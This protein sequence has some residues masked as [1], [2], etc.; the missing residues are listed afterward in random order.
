MAAGP[1]GAAR[2]E[3]E[4]AVPGAERAEERKVADQNFIGLIS[5]NVEQTL[6]ATAPHDPERHARL[7]ALLGAA[8]DLKA[9][10]RPV[11]GPYW[12]AATP[13]QKDRIVTLLHDHLTDLYADQ[14]ADYDGEVIRVADSKIM[15]ESPSVVRTEIVHPERPL[16]RVDFWVRRTGKTYRVLDVIIEGTSLLVTKR[17]EFQAVI[18]GQGIDGLIARLKG[19]KATPAG[20]RS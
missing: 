15:D 3:A 13:A 4:N 6:R 18:E 19:L 12:R 7:H 1:L 9:F 8:F 5:A 14:F 2:A 10:A 11:V 20:P 16:R 17:A